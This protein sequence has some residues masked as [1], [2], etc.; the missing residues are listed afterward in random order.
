M[1]RQILKTIWS[2]ILVSKTGSS[3]AVSCFSF[4]KE[5]IYK[6]P[7]ETTRSA[8]QSKRHLD[9]IIV[10]QMAVNPLNPSPLDVSKPGNANIPSSSLFNYSTLPSSIVSINASVTK[11]HEELMNEDNIS[12]LYE[13]R[14]YLILWHILDMYKY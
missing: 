3:L 8:G 13:F 7:F 2:W 10:Q 9:K 1:F 11:F 5:Q 14:F 6:E 12:F 4:I